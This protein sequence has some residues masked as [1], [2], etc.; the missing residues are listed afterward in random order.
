M[1]IKLISREEKDVIDDIATIHMATFQGFFLTFMGKKF[2]K[3]MYRS[4]V[5]H[6]NSGILV[7]FEEEKA[8]GFLAYSGNFSELY[9]YMIKRKLIPFAWYSAGAFFR[10]PKIFIRLIKAFL[11]PGEAKRAEEYVELASIGVAPDFKAKGVGSQLI[12]ALKNIVDLNRYAYISLETDAV[13]NEAANNFYKKNEFKLIREYATSEGRKM[14]EY[15]W[16]L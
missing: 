7:A 6:N 8:V 14:F 13:D 3:L 1:Q 11:K 9:K 10:K 15:R 16:S 5:E 12:S 4:Y 2:L